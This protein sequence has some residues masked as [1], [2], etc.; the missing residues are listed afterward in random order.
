MPAGALQRFPTG[1][2]WPSCRNSR[3]TSSSRTIRWRSS[4]VLPTI[5]VIA[6]AL[7]HPLLR[8][9][10]FLIVGHTNATGKPEHN[11]ELSLQRANAI[12]IALMTT[13]SIPAN[14]LEAVGAGQEWPL[15]GTSPKDAKNRRVQLIN[16]GPA[17]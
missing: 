16:L 1:A 14:Q 10:R 7:H 3:S 11:L 6:D 5:G 13:F 2:C 15:D 4:H 9:Y 8:N 17:R 12:K